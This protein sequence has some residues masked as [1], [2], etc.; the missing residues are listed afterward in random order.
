MILY[1]EA[2]KFLST[3]FAEVFVY[4]NLTNS[5]TSSFLVCIVRLAH[6][7]YLFFCKKGI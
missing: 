7:K 6:E 4:C 5:S 3:V 1:K 2:R